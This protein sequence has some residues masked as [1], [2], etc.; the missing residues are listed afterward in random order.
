MLR[1]RTGIDAWFAGGER[2]PVE[3]RSG[4]FHAFTRIEGAGP[5][6]TLLHGFPTCSW[7]WADSS[8]VLARRWRLL[9][10]DL[11]GYGDSD[12]PLRHRYSIGEQA[13]LVEALWRRYGVGETAIVAHDI[14]ATV[15][16]ELLA[17]QREAPPVARVTS[18]VFLNHGLYA[19]L[20]RPRLIQR[21]LRTPFG[22]LLTR[23]MTER[24]FARMFVRIFAPAH[25]PTP[26]EL[27]QHWLGIHRRGG[28]RNYHLLIRFMDERAASESRWAGAVEQA[29]VPCGFVWGVLDPI[30]GAQMAAR[31]RER[32]PGAPFVEVPDV[33]HYPQLEAPERTAEAISDLLSR[34]TG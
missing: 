28:V 13:D 6:L 9:M 14:G 11:L 27:H 4:L 25:R 22:P 26:G 24:V 3:L 15:G 31:V 33:G 34:W 1:A 8:V 2:V 7:D 20:Y 21:L 29:T 19:D 18:A 5:W 12:K 17:R 30:S 23:S 10:P 16:Q 32:V